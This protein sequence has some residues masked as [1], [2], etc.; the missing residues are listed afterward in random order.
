MHITIP[1]QEEVLDSSTGKKYVS[2]N[3]HINGTYHCSARFSILKQLHERLKKQFGQGCLEKFPGGTLFYVKPDSKDA[4][5]R[6][7]HLQAWIQKIGSQALLVDGET[8]QTFLLNSQ[9]E[10]QKG[11]EEDVQLEIYLA[12]GKSVKVDIVSTDQ[13]DDV[14]ETATTVIGLDSSLVYY[15]G[16]Y[17]VE[18]ATGKVIVR[19]LQD[20]ESPYVSLQRAEKGHIVQLRKAYWDIRVDSILQKNPTALNLLYIETINEI[21]KGSIQV[22]EDAADELANFRSKKERKAFLQLAAGLK[23]Y[24]DSSFGAALTN[25]PKPGT[26]V[27]LA[28]GNSLMKMQLVDDG[29]THDPLAEHT[30][31]VQRMRCWKTATL[32]PGPS[33]PEVDGKKVN[34]ELEFEYYLEKQNKMQWI[35]VLS[36]QAIHI[37]MCLQF[38]VEEMLRLKRNKP[39]RKPSDRVNS[40]KPRRQKGGGKVDLDFLTGGE[41]APAGE[42]ADSSAFTISVKLSELKKLVK[43][44]EAEEDEAVRK[45]AQSVTEEMAASGET[46]PDD[47]DDDEDGR[48]SFAAMAGY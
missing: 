42:G 12:H 37:S 36:P 43:A 20:F 48:N 25:Y 13:T 2:Y 8:F 38:M 15:F 46:D 45:L 32:M 3:I 5:L 18:D 1:N 27:K 40:F 24:G 22:E 17:L 9:K 29:G 7:F 19:K 4:T 11:P 41:A 26:K 39:I 34:V 28:L 21:K 44:A 23:G 10:V 33:I 16:L 30:F 31:Q 35:K 47:Y 14:L 6:R